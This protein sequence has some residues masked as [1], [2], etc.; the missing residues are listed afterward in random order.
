[1]SIFWWIRRSPYVYFIVRELTSIFVAAYAVILLLQLNALR[2][3]PE[4]WES[5]IA[6][7]SAPFSIA[8]HVII[9]L[10]V[11][12]HTFTWF[13]LAPSAMVLKVGKTKIPGMAIIA[14]NFVMWIILSAA[15]VW[16]I[17][18]I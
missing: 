16:I 15:I 1:M 14:V 3:G 2:H 10:F 7:F 6:T 11:L 12:F 8:L 5:L 4:A 17:L 9:L 13:K 18:R